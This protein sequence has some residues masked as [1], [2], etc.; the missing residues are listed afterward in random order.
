MKSN[1]LIK[2]VF[3]LVLIC[4]GFYF[5]VSFKEG[6]I[7]EKGRIAFEKGLNSSC[8]WDGGI[9]RPFTKKPLAA[10]IGDVVL[11]ARDAYGS[12]YAISYE[13]V[14][15]DKKEATLVVSCNGRFH[16]ELTIAVGQEIRIEDPAFTK[17]G[18]HVLLAM[19][20]AGDG[21]VQFDH[22]RD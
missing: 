10:R 4:G 8:G 15:S 5:R 1:V 7:K 3:S 9:V 20:D 21:D 6:Q 14:L 2:V 22:R 11:Y 16:D 13:R 18:G 19:A 17:D 12:Y